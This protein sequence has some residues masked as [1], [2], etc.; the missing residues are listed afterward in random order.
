MGDTKQKAAAKAFTDKWLA[1]EGYEKGET[2]Q[3]W[4]DLLH[5]VYGIERVTEYIEFEKRIKLDN[6]A[7]GFIDGYIPSVPVLI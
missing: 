1:K 4:T 5:D 7:H 6:N 2:Q 3:F